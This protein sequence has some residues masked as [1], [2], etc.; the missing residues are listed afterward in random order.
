MEDDLLD[1]ATISST[2][3]ACFIIA[4]IFDFYII[5]ALMCGVAFG[6]AQAAL[7]SIVYPR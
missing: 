2:G 7:I 4:L 3:I 5:P 6:A 1:L